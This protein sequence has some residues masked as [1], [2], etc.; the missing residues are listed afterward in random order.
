MNKWV[1]LSK[2]D[3]SKAKGE[4]KIK[5]EKK[6]QLLTQTFKMEI[7]RGKNPNLEN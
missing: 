2:I 6:M 4:K 7:S 3:S 5:K 1:E